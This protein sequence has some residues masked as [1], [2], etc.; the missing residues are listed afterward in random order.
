MDLVERMINKDKWPIFSCKFQ[1]LR[2]GVHQAAG[3]RWL[4]TT[5]CHF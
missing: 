1:I 4:E 5:S 2:D 3:N